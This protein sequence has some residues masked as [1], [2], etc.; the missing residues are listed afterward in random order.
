MKAL[1]KY[2]SGPGNMEI[3]DI[4]EPSPG[5]G[6]VKIEVKEA[7]IC[8]SDIH[9]YHS[10]IAIPL[11]P[12]VVTGHEF[13]GIV[14]ENVEGSARFKPGTRV[15]SETAF[16]YCGVCD[17]CREGFYNLCVERR[18]LGYWFNGVFTRYTVVPEAR[19]HAIPDSVDFTSA[20]MTEPLACVAH[21][22]Y[23]LTR[24]VAGDVV[25]VSGP[26][27]VGLMAAQIAKAHGAT[28]VVSGTD[29]DTARLEMAKKLG[30]DYTVNVQKENLNEFIGGVTRGYGADVVLEC[31]GSPYGTDAGLN[32]VKKRG[33]FTQIGLPGKKI[34]FDIEKVCYKELHFSGSLGSRNASWRKA[35][36]L[37]AA[38]KVNVKPLVSDKI[39]ILEWEIA[40]KKFESKEGGKIF[41]LPV[42][43]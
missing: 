5:P 25:L 28:V 13:S 10:D 16:H 34:E 39:S 4:P 7:G 18:T 42:L 37:L 43:E 26:G 11:N 36:D 17:F 8:G 30:A 20:A 22:V 12:P 31:S 33:W 14:V 2:A 15:V 3:R 32:A 24:V 38:G 35:L 40:F 27:S 6:Q 21:A 23:D 1:V 19:I 9:I 41:L 29:V